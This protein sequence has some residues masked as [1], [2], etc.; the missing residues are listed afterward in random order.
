MVFAGFSGGSSNRILS[1]GLLEILLT[2]G[3]QFD[4][5]VV[6]LM[7]KTIS[8]YMSIYFWDDSKWDDYY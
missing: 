8:S 5:I 1:H 2:V 3:R 6:T 7:S 4:S